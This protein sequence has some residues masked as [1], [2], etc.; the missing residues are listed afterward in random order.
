MFSRVQGGTSLR[1]IIEGPDYESRSYGRVNYVDASVIAVDDGYHLLATNR[2]PGQPMQ[3]EVQRVDSAMESVT[4]SVVLTAGDAKSANSWDQPDVVGTGSF[5]EYK[6][7]NGKL[8]CELP[9][10]SLVGL[11]LI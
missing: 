6:V 8:L 4:S 5:N 11:T 7:V 1:V 3:I 2:H 9:P 10:L